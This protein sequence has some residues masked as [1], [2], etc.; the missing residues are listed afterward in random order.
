[1][2][3]AQ[4]VH[5]TTHLTHYH[6]CAY[7]SSHFVPIG[8]KCHHCYKEISFNT[9][10]LSIWC[11]QH[12][13]C[14]PL[15]S[16]SGSATE[17]PGLVFRNYSGFVSGILFWTWY[18]GWFPSEIFD[19]KWSGWSEDVVISVMAC[20]LKYYRRE[21]IMKIYFYWKLLCVHKVISWRW[22]EWGIVLHEISLLPFWL[23]LWLPLCCR[24]LTTT[25]FFLNHHCYRFI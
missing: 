16:G 18:F 24:I 5:P 6:L 2:W 4:F 13:D 1:M 11:K 9:G 23:P 20:S 22:I 7:V 19:G 15:W 21:D 3:R 14:F 17:Q 12:W 10:L 25:K 8:T